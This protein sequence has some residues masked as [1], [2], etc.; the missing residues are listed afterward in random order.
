MAWQAVQFS[1]QHPEQVLVIVVGEFHVQYGGGLPYRIVSR[2]PQ[3]KIVTLS[4]I[5][6]EGYTDEDVAEALKPSETEGPRADF[7][8]VSRP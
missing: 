5:W 4:Q 7:I 2:W 8:W 3:A 1:Q 6:G